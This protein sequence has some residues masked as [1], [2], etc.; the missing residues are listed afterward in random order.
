MNI[1]NNEHSLT[2]SDVR[3]LTAGTANETKNKVRL[4]FLPELKH[5]DFNCSALDFL[6]SSGL[7]ALISLQK[8][9]SERGGRFRLLSPKPTIIQVLEMTRLHRVFEIVA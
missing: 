7:G 8:L 5:I 1:T 9:A 3:E 2:I 6:D 4:Q